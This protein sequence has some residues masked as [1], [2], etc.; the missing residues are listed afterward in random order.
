MYTILE[1]T[2]YLIFHSQELIAIRKVFFPS[3]MDMWNS[4]DSSIR[5][6]V[7]ISSFKCKLKIAH[8]IIVSEVFMDSSPRQLNIIL[9]QLRNFKSDL[10]FDKHSDHLIDNSSCVCGA[11]SEDL[12]HFFFQCPLYN[13]LRHH[14]LSIYNL[15]GYVNLQCLLCGIRNVHVPDQINTLILSHVNL[16]IKSSKRFSMYK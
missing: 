9:C 15:L 12:V 14:I 7:S 3:T 4:L 1:I 6:S 2:E 10:N 8:D 11:P 13:D 5:D 16:Y